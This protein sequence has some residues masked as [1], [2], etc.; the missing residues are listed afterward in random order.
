MTGAITNH[1]EDMNIRLYENAD[2]EQVLDLFRLNVPRYFAAQEEADLDNYLDKYLEYHYV[3]EADGMIV[4]NGGFNL[5][6]DG[7]T[8]SLS[9][10]FFHPQYQGKGLGTLLTRFRIQQI[11]ERNNVKEIE[12]RTSQYTYKFYERFG[13][14]IREVIKDYWGDGLDLYHMAGSVD[15]VK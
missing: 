14:Q 6:N 7:S 13:L 8:A 1:P 4:G 2:K 11:K 3:M 10:G 9:W 15:S 12:V 5:F